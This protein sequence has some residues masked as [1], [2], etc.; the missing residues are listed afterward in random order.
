MI[1][2]HHLDGSN[3]FFFVC[4]EFKSD[5]H[6]KCQLESLGISVNS[7]SK[8]NFKVNYDFSTNE[9]WGTRV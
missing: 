8:I 4:A 6:D 7:R 9:A 1:Q 5:K 2:G 3:I